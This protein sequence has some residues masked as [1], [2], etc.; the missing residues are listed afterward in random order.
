MAVLGGGWE[1]LRA[2]DIV[3]IKVIDTPT[4]T[5]IFSKD[6]AVTEG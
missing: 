5:A 1:Q 4:G 2:G 6:V 3:N